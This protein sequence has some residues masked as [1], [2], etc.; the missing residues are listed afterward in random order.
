MTSAHRKHLF[1][2]DFLEMKVP[3]LPEMRSL[4]DEQEDQIGGETRSKKCTKRLEKLE[5]RPSGDPQRLERE[6]GR[7]DQDHH[8]AP[9]TRRMEEKR[10]NNYTDMELNFVSNAIQLETLETEENGDNDIDSELIRNI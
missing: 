5:T 6:I 10:R 2:G 7:G 4:G 1:N 3:E 9:D 8:G